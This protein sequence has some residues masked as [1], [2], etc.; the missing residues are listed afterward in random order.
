MTRRKVVYLQG[1][2]GAAYTLP[3][4][5]HRLYQAALWTPEA[6]DNELVVRPGVVAGPSN[7][8]NV[9]AASGGVNIAPGTAIVQGTVTGVQGMYACTWDAVTYRAAPR[10]SDSTYRKFYVVARV[11]DQLA[12]AGTDDWDLEVVLGS[13]A[14]SVSAAAYPQLPDNCAILRRGS[15]GPDG[16]VSVTSALPDLTVARGGVLPVGDRDSD[17]GAYP[18]HCRWVTTGLQT[19]DG[20]KWQ[21]NGH[22]VM[23]SSDRKALDTSGTPTGTLVYEW[24]TGLLIRWSGGIWRIMSSQGWASTGIINKGFVSTSFLWVP[25][26]GDKIVIPADGV[27]RD[28]QANVTVNIKDAAFVRL[29]RDLAAGNGKP[30]ATTY[31]PNSVGFQGFTSSGD[32]VS[33]AFGAA[34]SLLGDQAATYY[35]E[36]RA[37]VTAKPD[38]IIPTVQMRAF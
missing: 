18:G 1:V 14:A 2:N 35:L 37:V 19:W 34:G 9:G 11:Y 3:A 33:V 17:D 25:G 27:Q 6:N 38:V 21:P 29:R 30:A 24:D 12:S 36:A 28:W 16:V 7:P 20:S 31:W 4:E 5:D 22:A 13:G 32:E 26:L 8:A 10:A 15:V 23:S